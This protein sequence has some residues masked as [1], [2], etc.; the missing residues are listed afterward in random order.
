M[1][2]V[3]DPGHGGIKDPGA[4]G[5]QGLRESD[6]TYAVAKLLVCELREAG[7]DPA[8]TRGRED[9]PT[10][11]ARAQFANQLGAD[12]YL[13]IHANAAGGGG[14]TAQGIEAWYHGRSVK[15]QQL[16]TCLYNALI[17]EFPESVRRG[18]KSDRTRYTSGF[19][20]LRETVMPAAM[21]ELEFISHPFWEAEMRTKSW[22]KRAARAL[23]SGL[24]EYLMGGGEAA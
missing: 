3:V 16:A 21:V 20:V 15:G 10:L 4:V 24:H 12:L 13:S 5:P 22:R 2:I 18:V 8:L 6:V 11:S 23:F 9:N 14:G 19:A 17:D 1:T 7:L